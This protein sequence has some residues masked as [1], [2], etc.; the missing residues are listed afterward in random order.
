[1]AKR[2]LVTLCVVWFCAACGDDDR[3]VV[4]VEAGTDASRDAAG[5]ADIDARA[6]DHMDARVDAQG[7]DASVDAE[8]DA[9]FDAGLDA[10][11]D[12]GPQCDAAQAPSL[13]SLALQVV[14][15]AT[16]LSNLVY[17]AQA[18]GSS[19]WYLVQLTGQV[20]VLSNGVLQPDNFVDVSSEISAI[21]ERG[22]LSIAFPPD[23]ATSGRFYIALTPTDGPDTNRDGVYEYRRSPDGKTSTRT[24][25]I[26]QLPTSAANH[27]GGTVLFGPDGF[28]YYGSGDGGG[29][30]NDFQP[31]GPQNRGSLFGKVLRLDPNAADPFVAPGNPFAPDAG[32]PR[33]WQY[34]LRNPFRFG[35]DRLTGALFIGDVGQGTYEELD[36][37]AA[38]AGGQNFGWPAFEGA[39]ADTCGTGRLIGDAAVP[40]IVDIPRNVANS[41]ADWN[42]VI[43]GPTYRGTE[44][45]A[46]RG[47]TLFGDYVGVRMGALVQCGAQTSS[48]TVIA[49]NRDP[50]QPSQLSFARASG[51]PALD[52][53]AAIVE[54]NAGELYFVANGST[55]L[56][57]V[58]G[59]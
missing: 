8:V 38:D 23:Y 10:G 45:P 54:D 59:P 6:P 39:H 58:A 41:F 22:L 14:P 42:S 40:P 31:G 11:F 12:A 7:P 37:A 13:P 52:R 48:V 16:G 35:V 50:N 24:R 19:D 49:K 9:S 1:M 44:L 21:D 32:D 55:L 2:W 33:V 53:L 36:F 30:C 26:V 28:L 29:S 51:V 43:G 47:V 20:R 4:N 25:L 17:A 56:K 27:N 18:P 34:G 15:G 3:E 46:L 57:V 5:D